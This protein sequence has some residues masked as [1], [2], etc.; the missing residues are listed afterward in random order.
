MNESDNKARSI[1]DAVASTK[2]I[3][4][5][6]LTNM[7][8][9]FHVSLKSIYN[10]LDNEDISEASNDNIDIALNTNKYIWFEDTWVLLNA[11]YHSTTGV[12]LLNLLGNNLFPQGYTKTYISPSV[13]NTDVEHHSYV[14]T[15]ACYKF[16]NL[17]V[18]SYINIDT[19]N[20]HGL[21]ENMPKYIEH[22]ILSE[23]DKCEIPITGSVDKYVN[24]LFKIL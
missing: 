14:I 11:K 3:K 19:D 7:K 21:W 18:Y 15:K 2:P 16:G 24:T 12:Q 9:V 13:G 17:Q 1:V 4:D 23:L 6:D 20:V 10:P 8:E 5:V 22:D